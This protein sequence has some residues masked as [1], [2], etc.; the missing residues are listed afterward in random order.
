MTYNQESRDIWKSHVKMFEYWKEQMGDK[1][2]SQHRDGTHCGHKR[3]IVNQKT[4]ISEMKYHFILYHSLIPLDGLHRSQDTAE[5]KFR[6]Q[7]ERRHTLS[8]LTEGEEVKDPSTWVTYG[9][10]S[11]V[12]THIQ[13]ASQK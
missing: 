3:K 12:L 7:E 1:G 13:L 8:R 5:E 6:E 2:E 4:V 9:R 10:V 11:S